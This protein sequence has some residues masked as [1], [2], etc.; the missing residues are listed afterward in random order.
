MAF[1][2]RSQTPIKQAGP[3][4]TNRTKNHKT[5]ESKVDAFL[6]G[7]NSKAVKDSYLSKGGKQIDNIR[8]AS[9]GRYTQEAIYDKL[10]RGPL[11]KAIG[12]LGSN[13]LGVAHEAKGIVKDKRPWKTKLLES[14][15]DMVNNAVGSVVG[16]MP[17]SSKSKTNII[18]KLSIDNILPNGYDSNRASKNKN[19]KKHRAK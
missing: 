13:L 1:N 6:G 5:L 2:L 3:K 19:S 12:V 16:A 14:G 10:P 18:K 8:H 4:R 15:E 11:S 7:V 17:I 9:A